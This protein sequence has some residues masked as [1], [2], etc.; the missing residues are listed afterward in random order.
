[1]TGLARRALIAKNVAHVWC[2]DRAP[3]LAER[4]PA[5]G[6]PGLNEILRSVRCGSLGHF[7]GPQHLT[8]M[9]RNHLLILGLAALVVAGCQGSD[10]RL[11]LVVGPEVIVPPGVRSSQTADQVVQKT[12]EA[13]AADEAK[14][15]RV[16]AP[17]RIIRI[18]LLGKGETY[19]LK[20]L[21]GDDPSGMGLG[22]SE[23][24]GW[25]VEAMGTFLYFDW[26]KGDRLE[27]MGLHGI[28]AWDDSGGSGQAFYSCWSLS[29]MP[30]ES[31]DGRCQ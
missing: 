1:M 22:P 26:R 10:V 20:Q 29:P 30:A 8:S 23:G 24:P 17:A 15:G 31:Y 19:F 18:R 5:I 27:D 28:Y 12:L 9:R 14:L 2:R 16:L 7:G 11:P 13:I 21:D 6:G 25:V 4:A 3:S